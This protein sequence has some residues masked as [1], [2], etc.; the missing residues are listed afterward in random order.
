ME[1]ENSRPVI[2]SLT[3][4]PDTVGIAGTAVLTCTATDSDGDSL[5]FEWHAEVGTIDQDGATATWTAADSVGSHSISVVVSD[6]RGGR[7][8]GDLTVEVVGGTLLVRTRD[9]LIAVD[10]AGSSFTFYEVPGN[11]EVLGSRIFIGGGDNVF[12][13]DHAGEIIASTRRP[14]EIPFT[15]DLVVLPDGGFA[16]LDSTNDQ[17]GFMGPGGEFIRNVDYPEASPNSLQSADGMVVDGQLIASETGTNKLVR[18]DLTSYEATIFRDLSHLEGS[19]SGVEHQDGT[20]YVCQKSKVHRFTAEGALTQL[21]ELDDH[22]I[23][24][25]ALAEDQAYVV[26]NRGGRIHQIDT[27]TGESQIFMEGLDYP[28]EIEYIPVRLVP[29]P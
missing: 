5:G 12:E 19:L 2:A 1:P 18:V 22:N 14:P 8:T 6:G 17:V 26:T 25:I 28:E 11:V 10:L 27:T 23:T 29:T 24:A 21:C 16:H 13:L 9:G 7:A 3:A 15:Y 20:Y 4:E